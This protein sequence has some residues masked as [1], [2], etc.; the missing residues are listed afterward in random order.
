MGKRQEDLDDEAEKFVDFESGI[1]WTFGT[2]G[3]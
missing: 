2:V 1:Y 3:S